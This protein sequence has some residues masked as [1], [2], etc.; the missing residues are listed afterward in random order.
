MF[1][2]NP[3]S[4]P[5]ISLADQLR[6]EMEREETIRISGIGYTKTRHRTNRVKV[7]DGIP[8]QSAGGGRRRLSTVSD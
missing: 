4:A 3:E 5:R 8:Y 6:R 7:I 2:S 1:L